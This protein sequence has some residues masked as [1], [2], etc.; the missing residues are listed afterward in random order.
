MREE[1]QETGGPIQNFADLEKRLK[2]ERGGKKVMWGKFTNKLE[3]T[4]KEI[5]ECDKV[6]RKWDTLVS[7]YKRAIDQNKGTGNAPT[8]FEFFQEM[9]G[10]SR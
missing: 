5:F 4:F 3:N 6:R 1:I 2:F 8:K 7:G 9:G 10:F